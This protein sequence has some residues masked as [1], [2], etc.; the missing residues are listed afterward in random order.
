MTWRL[1]PAFDGLTSSGEHLVL[2][3]ESVKRVLLVILSHDIPFGLRTRPFFEMI[4]D[5][6]TMNSKEFHDMIESSLASPLATAFP[7]LPFFLST[8]DVD[9]TQNSIVAPKARS[10]FSHRKSQSASSSSSSGSSALRSP[11]QSSFTSAK[12]PMSYQEWLNYDRSYERT[13]PPRGANPLEFYQC[14]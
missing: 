13:P 5:T 8:V 1:S 9:Q 7:A 6:V 2:K 4:E 10:A 14:W 12:R 3:D 11:Y